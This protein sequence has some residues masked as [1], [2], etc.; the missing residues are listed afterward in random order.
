MQCA[1]ID[2]G[3]VQKFSDAR[4]LAEASV[5]QLPTNLEVAAT[6]GWVYL[7]MNLI[8]EAEQIFKRIAVGGQ[9]QP[10]TAYYLACFAERSGKRVAAVKTLRASLDAPGPFLHRKQAEQL[11]K[12]I[13]Q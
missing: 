6:L 8:E 2:M 7:E 5:R 3:D 11:L 10:D 1:L 4:A 12:K 9:A 13:D